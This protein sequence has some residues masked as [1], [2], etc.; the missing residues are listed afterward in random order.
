MDAPG[1]GIKRAKIFRTRFD[2]KEFL[3]RFAGLSRDENLLVLKRGPGL[4]APVFSSE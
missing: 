3:A 4:K 2:R 1:R